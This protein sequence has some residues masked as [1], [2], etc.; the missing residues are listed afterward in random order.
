MFPYGVSAPSPVSSL[1]YDHEEGEEGEE[2]D[3]ATEDDE[4]DDEAPEDEDD[5]AAPEK[6]NDSLVQPTGA[7]QVNRNPH[8]IYMTSTVSATWGS[9]T[10]QGHQ[11]M[12]AP[13]DVV[14]PALTLMQNEAGRI[15]EVSRSNSPA[16]SSACDS[17]NSYSPSDP[18]SDEPQTARY[19]IRRENPN[20]EIADMYEEDRSEDEGNKSRLLDPYS[21]VSEHA[22]DN[23][24]SKQVKDVE[25]PPYPELF[26]HARPQPFDFDY[27]ARPRITHDSTPTVPFMNW[28]P[29]PSL[30]LQSNVYNGSDLTFGA[31]PGETTDF[32]DYLPPS[33]QALRSFQHHSVSVA[34][35]RSP[36][37]GRQA[38]VENKSLPTPPVAPQDTVGPSPLPEKP[39]PY[40]EPPVPRLNKTLSIAEMV[41]APSQAPLS[42]QQPLK[43]KA[44]VLEQDEDIVPKTHESPSKILSEAAKSEQQTAAVQV[45]PLAPLATI[46]TQRPRKRLRGIISFASTVAAGVAVGAVAV[47]GGL[48]ALPEGFFE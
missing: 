39:Q 7:A 16:L 46:D 38:E 21:P 45:T 24:A 41:D 14:T 36:A 17:E 19:S 29:P 22:E 2:G 34:S 20:E 33:P 30:P 44:D 48:A 11:S 28:V 18:L 32:F 6:R 31:E 3:F 10:P 8:I 43:R 9:G 25:S 4:D 23:A 12:E 42:S 1:D 40:V 35:R 47:V 27:S 13:E 5:N 15:V 26:D 37:Y